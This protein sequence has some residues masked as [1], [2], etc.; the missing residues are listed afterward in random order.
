MTDN[1]S[2]QNVRSWIVE[3]FSIPK[4]LS[5]DVYQNETEK[6]DVCTDIVINI[7]SNNNSRYTIHKKISE[8]TKD[9]ILL[10]KDSVI[11][12]AANEYSF[13]ARLPGF[14]GWWIIFAGSFSLFSVCPVCGNI[15]CPMGI[16]ITGLL[17]AF[18]AFLKQFLKYYLLNLK[19]NFIN[20]MK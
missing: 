13:L 20:K 12:Y 17:A 16:G 8:I 14:F 9:D 3:I 11:D 7:D 6:K 19:K 10:L 18:L 15:G 1:S 2:I 4:C 5:I